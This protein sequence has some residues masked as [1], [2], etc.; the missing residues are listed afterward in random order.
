MGKNDKKDESAKDTRG[1]KKVKLA[2][3]SRR[4]ET[5]NFALRMQK[6]TKKFQPW[7]AKARQKWGFQIVD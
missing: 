3:F 5:R 1:N 7:K 2:L 4:P 6:E